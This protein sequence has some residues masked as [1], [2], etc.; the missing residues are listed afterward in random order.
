MICGLGAKEWIVKLLQGMYENRSRVRVGE[1]L[2]DKF[3]V[4]VGVRQGSV[5]SPLLFIFV[6]GVS[7]WSTLGGP[8]CR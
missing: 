5:L 7:S 4:K 1:G 3:D 8:L 6:T 2:S